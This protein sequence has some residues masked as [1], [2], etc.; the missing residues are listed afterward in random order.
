[1]RRSDSPN[2]ANHLNLDLSLRGAP[3]KEGAAAIH[4]Q[5]A[6]GLPIQVVS[7]IRF[8]DAL[9]CALSSEGGS[10]A[11]ASCSASTKKS[12]NKAGRRDDAPG[13]RIHADRTAIHHERAVSL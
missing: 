6:Q 1:L 3:F 2:R 13:R 12:L 5:S 8:P 11:S 4:P 10:V 7:A 9:A